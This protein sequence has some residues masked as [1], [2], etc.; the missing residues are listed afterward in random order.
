MAASGG[1]RA[2]V[3]SPLRLPERPLDEV[4]DQILTMVSCVCGEPGIDRSGKLGRIAVRT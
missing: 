2:E 4:F 3:M 1:M